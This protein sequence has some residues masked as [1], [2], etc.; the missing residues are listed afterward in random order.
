MRS[1]VL[2]PAEADEQA[3]AP[4][5]SIAVTNRRKD[6]LVICGPVD[7]ESSLT[8]EVF[9]RLLRQTVFSA[10]VVGA[11]ACHDASG[12]PTLPA[13]YLLSSINGRPLPTYLAPLPE[14]PTVTYST[15]F[16]GSAGNAVL[17]EHRQVMTAPG[18]VTY[19][20][21]FTYSIHD[22]TIDFHIDCPDN[23]LCAAPVGKFVNSHLLV[24]FSGGTGAV[25]YDYQLVI[26]D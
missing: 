22:N 23:A 5:E 15:L 18:D 10:I 24:D 21:N 1:V 13:N 25:V 9:M 11:I 2:S 17:I 12:P 16:L 8:P 26:G 4:A 6:G 7:L 14:S 3:S 20:T 19:T